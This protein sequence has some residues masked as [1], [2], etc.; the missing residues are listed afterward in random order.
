LTND[1]PK[2]VE[3]Y[4]NTYESEDFIHGGGIASETIELKKGAESLKA[5]A[6]SIEP[7]LRKL[8]LPT[9]LVN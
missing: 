1:S 4:F 7:Y 8:G 3:N 2:T 9:T 6:H 5:F